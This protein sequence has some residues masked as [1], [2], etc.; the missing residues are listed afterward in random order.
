MEEARPCSPAPV[1]S[2]PETVRRHFLPW[3]RPLLP[4]AV[5]FLTRGWAGDGP[6]DLSGTL[7]VVPTRQAGRRL[8]EAL[9]AHA[10]E[11]GSA[12]FPPRVMLPESLVSAAVGEQATA[13]RLVS[14]LAWTEVLRAIA[15][16]DF[17]AVF[18]VD[19]PVRNLAWALRLAQE[20]GRLRR[21]LGEGGLQMGDVAARVGSDFPES[22]RWVQLAELERLH[23][24]KLKSFELTDR[25]LAE[26]EAA[27]VPAAIEGVERIVMIGAPDPLP[28]ALHVLGAQAKRMPVEVLVFAPTAEAEAFDAWGRP[29]PEAWGRR[30]IA[31]ADFERTVHLC[32]NPVAQAERIAKVARGYEAPE[33]VVG[34]GVADAE[35]LPLLAGELQRAGCAAFNPEGRPRKGDALHQLLTAL[36]MLAREDSF[37][38]VA[39]LARCPDFLGFATRLGAEGSAAAFLRDLDALRQS[40]LPRS[41]A[42]LRRHAE[43]QVRVGAGTRVVLAAIAELREGV[44][45]GRFPEN[46]GAA[47]GRIFGG[48]RFDLAREDEADVAEAAEAWTNVMREIAGAA[49]LFPEVAANEWWEVALRLYGELVRYD[50]KPDGALELQGWLELLWEDAPH[51][52]VAG[53]NDGRVPDAIVGDPFLPES[54]RVRLGLKTNAARF[55]RDAYLLQALVAW[56]AEG[57]RGR[58][59]LFLG[60]TSVSGDPLRPSRLLLRCTDEEL[61]RRVRFLFRGTAAGK[62]MPAWRRAWRLT[63]RRVEPPT[64]VAVTGL[65]AWLECPFRFYLSRVLRMEPVDPAKNELDAFDFGIL[66][67]AALE[68]MGRDAAMRD[69]TEAGTLR[70]FLLGLLEVETMRRLGKELTLPLTVQVESARQRLSRAAEV[71][72]QTRAE[73]WVILDV[74]RPFEI[75][76][77]GLTISGKIDRIDRHLETGAL[78]VVDYKTSDRPVDPAE[79]HLR[80]VRRGEVRPEFARFTLNA[81]ELTWK[82]LQLPLYLRALAAGRVAVEGATIDPAAA[83]AARG[84][85]FNL[86]KASTETGIREWDEYPRELDDAAWRCVVG[87]A[88]AIR[89][90]VF[91]P[92]NEN[93]RAEQDVF[94][95]LFHHG[96]ADSVAWEETG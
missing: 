78:R 79:A 74:E 65:R 10:A 20:F 19:P 37:D 69:C 50:D 83:R 72:A 12:V 86:P 70:E 67:H 8:R 29:Q 41:L 2:S 71:Q 4:Q 9:A 53:L 24:A 14:L 76:V 38:A 68:A 36:A 5:A 63:P 39:A 44:T 84:G 54:L 80:G 6:L 59:D 58:I 55:A 66:C 47:L 45:A 31:W 26:I 73:G 96:A 85:Y 23:T 35:V 61:P 93:V 1:S 94:A 56:R 22:E 32:A 15:L 95:A 7:A 11:R 75:E 48:R 3:D 57:E 62:P 81:R 43:Q 82:D 40:H 34:V 60:K 87:A 28:L 21:A 51:L 77:A 17:R 88:E 18:P 30:E 33:G 49:E 92:P 16:D 13:T 91:W 25:Q 42:E 52:V 64:R 89:A 90:G 27:R 46:A